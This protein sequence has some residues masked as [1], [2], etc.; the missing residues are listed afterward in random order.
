VDVRSLSIELVDPD[1]FS[2][3]RFHCQ[4]VVTCVCFHL[5]VARAFLNAL[6]PL[7]HLR[8][9]RSARCLDAFHD[10]SRSTL[11]HPPK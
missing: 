11:H 4:L 2:S 1:G 5:D 8:V 6:A 9:C 3:V 10:N 7:P